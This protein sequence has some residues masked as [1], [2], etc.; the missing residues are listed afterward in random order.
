MIWHRK[1]LAYNCRNPIIWEW[2]LNKFCTVVSDIVYFVKKPLPY[3]G[4][5]YVVPLSSSTSIPFS[6]FFLPLF[7]STLL[8]PAFALSLYAFSPSPLFWCA[9]APLSSAQPGA[10]PVLCALSSRHQTRQLSQFS[11]LCSKENIKGFWFFY[12]VAHAQL[13]NYFSKLKGKWLSGFKGIWRLDRLQKE[14]L[15]RISKL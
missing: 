12:H 6:S 11:D 1:K 9:P 7:C 4:P 14:R 8:L 10:P 13:W 15:I 5:I 3:L 2:R